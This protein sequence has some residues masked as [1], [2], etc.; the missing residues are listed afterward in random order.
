[1]T[2]Q[3]ILV[4]GGAGYIGSVLVGELLVRG[5]AVR[6]FDR[7][8]YGDQ[9]LAH[10]RHRIELVVGDMRA[11]DSAVFDGVS[12]V[13]NLG[14]LSNDP[15]AEFNPEA[16]YQMNTVAAEVTAKQAKAAGVERYL[17]ASS[18]SIYDLGHE[19]P[20]ADSIRD[21]E[22]AVEPRAAYAKSKYLAERAILP[23]A[24]AEFSPVILR[25]GTVYG[26][27]P[28]MRFDLVVNTFVK[29]ALTQGRMRLHH[30][31]ALWR[32]LVDIRE[33]VRI[34]L[35]CLEADTSTVRGQI[36]NVVGEN[37]RISELALRV[38][39]HLA[40]LGKC[41]PITMDEPTPVQ[42]SY[43]V[44]GR[45]LSEV[46]HCTLKRPVEKAITEM[47]REMEHLSPAWFENPRHYNIR[48]LQM[49][50]EAEGILGAKGTL[51][52]VRSSSVAA[53]EAA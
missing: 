5:Y 7:L 37:M 27:S 22:S 18:C 30:G 38:Q 47:V 36:F 40:T 50:E 32:P 26:W 16:N 6:V 31:G 1:M 14:G 19:H 28:R 8:L 34:Y 11:M 49:L 41:V 44:S 45:K 48:W 46:L 4:I 15:T 39:R 10:L 13:V 42:R 21:E 25:K 17:F 43:R 20:L 53:Q 9:G 35:T 33:V 52:G 23:L 12:A 24:D 3:R 29:D 51:W 2:S